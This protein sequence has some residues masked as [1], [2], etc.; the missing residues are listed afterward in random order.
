VELDVRGGAKGGGGRQG[1]WP[2][3][4]LQHKQE[5]IYILNFVYIN[6]YTLNF[7]QHN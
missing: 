1:P 4:R 5:Y 6:I 2:R 7:M 3:P